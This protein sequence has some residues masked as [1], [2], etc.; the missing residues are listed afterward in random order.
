MMNPRSIDMADDPRPPTE[1]EALFMMIAII[2][3]ATIV[4]NSIVY[5][6]VS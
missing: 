6:I 4:I 2:F 1:G 5:A 3:T